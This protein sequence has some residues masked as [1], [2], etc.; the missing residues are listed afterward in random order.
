MVIKMP[1][2]GWKL[3]SVREDTYRLF[4]KYRGL[5]MAREERKISEDEVVRTLLARVLPNEVAERT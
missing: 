4:Q 3:I 5:L 1:K 2:G